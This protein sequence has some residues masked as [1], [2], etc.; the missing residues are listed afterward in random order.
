MT[1]QELINRMKGTLTDDEFFLKPTEE[2]VALLASML[3]EERNDE[4][5]CDDLNLSWKWNARLRGWRSHTQ[6]RR[7]G[8]CGR[9]GGELGPG[10]ICRRNA[11]TGRVETLIAL[12]LRQHAIT[13][14]D[15][16]EKGLGLSYIPATRR[17]Y[18]DEFTLPKR[19]TFEGLRPAIDGAREL[20][21]EED[22]LHAKRVESNRRRLGLPELPQLGDQ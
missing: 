2:D 1:L 10:N 19:G 12:V 22:R 14:M 15:V 16:A 8:Y 17:W 4:C 6:V 18:I 20:A 9:C 11:D 5:F 7:T 3:P 13:L 21:A